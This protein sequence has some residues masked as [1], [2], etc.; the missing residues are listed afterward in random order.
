[1]L[2]AAATASHTHLLCSVLFCSVRLS[3]Y[4]SFLSTTESLLLHAAATAAHMSHSIQQGIR[5][6]LDRSPLGTA[7]GAESG[8][9]GTFID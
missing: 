4:P 3:I 7:D 8:T 9:V 5:L 6:G 1:M 2:H